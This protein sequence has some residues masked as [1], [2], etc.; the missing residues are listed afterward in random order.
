[1]IARL[2]ADVPIRV[3]ALWPA[4]AAMTGLQALVAF[5][6]FAPGVLAPRLGI[7]VG[8][9]GLFTTAVFAVGMATSLIGGRLARRFGP[10]AVAAFCA[11]A[12]A[13]GMALAS[14]GNRTAIIAAGLI[15]GLAFGPETPASST[16]LSK[17]ASDKQRPL[18]FSIRQTGNQIGAIIGSLSLPLVALYAPETGYWLITALALL[19]AAVFL[20]LSRS[21]DRMARGEGQSLDIRGVLGA[22]WQHRGLRTLAL[23]SLPFSAMQLAL[24]AFLVTYAVT[25]LRLDHLAAGVLLATAQAG[26]LIGRLFWG[27]VATHTVAPHRLLAGLGFGMS[28]AAVA[29]AVLAPG[30]A[31]AGQAGIAFLFGLTASGW[32][33]VFLAEVARLSPPDRVAE[34]TGAVLTASYAGLLLGPAL[35]AVTATAGTLSLSYATLAGL[36]FAATLQ[37][38]RAA[39]DRA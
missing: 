17:L 18:I 39:H 33:G 13:G 1:M 16:L 14:V 22:V 8:D 31:F 23:L 30:L 9:V 5:A 6:L 34:I 11:F 29:M 38:V 35:V 4:L 15:V 19:G 25:I 12:V 7:G 2:P 21:Y 3:P 26:G 28:C 27:L 37:L 10:C 36:A 24:N 32:N 20:L